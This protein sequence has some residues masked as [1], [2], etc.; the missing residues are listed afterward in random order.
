[1]IVSSIKNRV[2]FL[3]ENI[4]NEQIRDGIKNELKSLDGL[5]DIRMTKEIGSL[6][7]NYDQEKLPLDKI[8]DYLRDYIDVTEQ[9]K[10]E[11]NKKFDYM[12]KAANIVKKGM[13]K[14]KG[15]RGMKN[16]GS[17]SGNLV[18][19]VMDNFTGNGLVKTAVYGALGVQG[20]KKGKDIVQ[21]KGKGKKNSK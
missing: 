18:G 16:T 10:D 20:Y 8:K 5:K 17:N 12:N 4:K 7:I 9:V 3:D 14:G 19:M 13:G 2:R 15:G 6:L 11:T 21:G 1:M